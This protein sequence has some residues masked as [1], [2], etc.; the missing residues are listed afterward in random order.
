MCKYTSLVNAVRKFVNFRHITPMLIAFCL[1]VIASQSFGQAANIDQIRNGPANDPQ[2]WFF[3]DF[4]NPSWVNGNAGAS[5]A[6][7]QEGH[8][9]GYRSL[10]TGLSVGQQYEYTLEYDTRQSSKQAIDYLTHYQRLEPHGQ[11]VH[12][13]EVIDPTI[14]ILNGKEYKM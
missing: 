10:I 7:Y 2:K 5:T 3:N 11:F 8:S 14:F 1:I 9:I 12:P 4:D 6:H 13:A